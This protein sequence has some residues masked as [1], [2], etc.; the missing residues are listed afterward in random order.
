M[1]VLLPQGKQHY[2]DGA[3]VPLAGGKVFTYDVGTTNPRTT[4]SDEAQT[5]PNTNPVILD[6]RGEAVIFWSGDY[7]VTFQDSLGSTIWSVNGVNS[8]NA[9]AFDNYVIDTGAA[10]AYIANGIPVSSYTAGLRLAL[11][12]TNTNTGASTLNYNGL[13]VRAIFANGSPLFSGT[14]KA[15]VISLLEYDGTNFQLLNQAP[16]EQ[17]NLL[18]YG[19]IANDVTAASN[20]SSI[21]HTLCD[22]TTAGLTGWFYFPNTTGSDIYYFNNQVDIRNGMRFDLSGCNLIFQKALTVTDKFRGFLNVLTDVEI[23]NGTITVNVSG[24]AVTNGGSAIRVG[25][26]SGYPFGAWPAGVYDQDTLVANNLPLMGDITIRNMNFVSNNDPT[27]CQG[28]ILM[29]GGLRNCVFDNLHFDGSIL[30]PSGI[31][32]E[33]GFA[34]QNGAPVDETQWTSSHACNM[35]FRNIHCQHLN[36]GVIGYGIELGGAHH[37]IIDNLIVDHANGAFNYYCGEAMMWRPWAPTDV[38]GVKRGIVLRN[39]T[40]SNLTGVGLNL[41]GAS[42][43]FSSYLATVAIPDSKKVDLQSFDISGCAISANGFGLQATG[44]FDI[45]NSTLDGPSG[46]SQILIGD[47]VAQFNIENV[48][49]LNSGQYGI[50]GSQVSVATTPTTITAGSSTIAAPVNGM[51]AGES[52][53]FQGSMASVT[54]LTAGTIYYV[55]AAGLTSSAFSVSATVGG[56]A[57]VPAG[58]GTA[59]PKVSPA[60]LKSGTVSNCLIAGNAGGFGAIWSMCSSVLMNQNRIGFSLLYDGIA[61]TVQTNGIDI[62]YTSNGGTVICNGNFVS[63]VSG[64]AYLSSGTPLFGVGNIINPK[65]E[66][67]VGGVW[68]INGVVQA[69]SATGGNKLIYPNSFDKYS[70]KQWNNTSTNKLFIAQGSV[71][72]STWISVD[73]VTTITPA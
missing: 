48:R 11:L 42:N 73:G 17:N 23:A 5:N 30:C 62:S 33:F 66:N 61:E 44:S 70:G 19:L 35:T 45:R 15:G 59:T 21:L 16:Y 22:P 67:S 29:F 4:W 9:S 47:D 12:V 53:Y 58:S 10:N 8:N 72:T 38:E 3:G 28:I 46:S 49:I 71:N 37:C 34:S 43:Q 20:N 54:G 18:R 51:V 69:S 39:I 6:A 52:V 1:A 36:T 2:D 55:I 13:G 25:S 7:T 27:N 65:N 50:R 26:R 14:M 24:T 60:R 56:A 63:T 57:I 68:D 32:Y 40:G 31:V 41:G 64:T